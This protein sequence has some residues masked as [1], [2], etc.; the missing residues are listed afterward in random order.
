MGCG[1]NKKNKQNFNQQVP[2][3]TDVA[4]DA[5]KSPNESP[6]EF[7]EATK[8]Q[9]TGIN[10]TIS[11]AKSFASA[12]VS[13]GF[14]NE[15][16]NKQVKQLRVLSCFGNQNRGGELPPCEHLKQSTTEGKHYCGGC[17][18]GDKPGTWLMAE[19]DRYSKLDYPK[20]ACPLNMPGFSNYEPS[21]PDEAESPITRRYYIENID[22]N[23]ILKT[24]VSTPEIPKPPVPSTNTEISPEQNQSN[25]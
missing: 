15:K 19:G 14:S 18:C 23:E 8:T 12:I 9:P 22:F 24:P 16:A 3:N 25:T 2:Q 1:C 7:R 17:G 10:R 6:I 5:S 21:Q 4:S 13:R 20:L 11:M